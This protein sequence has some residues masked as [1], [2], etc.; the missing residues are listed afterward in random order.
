MFKYF[1]NGFTYAIFGSQSGIVDGQVQISF[2]W[3]SQLGM[4]LL[5]V[6]IIAIIFFFIT[7]LL[8]FTQNTVVDETGKPSM[9]QSKRLFYLK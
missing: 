4:M 2:S 7:F 1:G 6:F 9:M 3:N 5:M 8:T